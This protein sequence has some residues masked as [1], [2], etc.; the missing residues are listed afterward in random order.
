MITSLLQSALII[1]IVLVF[2]RVFLEKET[3]YQINRWILLGCMVL[4]FLLPHIPLKITIPIPIVPVQTKLEASKAE[5]ASPLSEEAIADTPALSEFPLEESAPAI[6]ARKAS[7]I[8]IFISKLSPTD[9]I[10]YLYLAGVFCMFTHF[11]VQII[12]LVQQIHLH[13]KSKE[14]KYILVE[15]HE[16]KA[17]YSFFNFIFINPKPLD[18]ATYQQVLSHERIHVDQNHSL[19]ILLSQV[20]LIIQWFNPFAW[21]Y[22][23]KVKQNLEY[24]TDDL[25]VKQGTDITDYQ[26]SLL[27]VSAPDTSGHLVLNYSQSLLKKRI[28][29]M[30][31]QKSSLLSTWKYVFLLPLLALSSFVLIAE[32]VPKASP[33]LLEPLPQQ[34]L[35]EEP[36]PEAPSLDPESLLT[37][38]FATE[39]EEISLFSSLQM[40]QTEE[41]SGTW[42][43]KIKEDELCLRV[44][45]SI[46]EED[47]NWMNYDCYAFSDFSPKV[48]D[49][50]SEFS[51]K[52]KAGTITF[53]GSFNKTKGEGKFQ[54]QGSDAYR[55]ELSEKG[56]KN[57][58]EDLLFRL[59]FVRNQAKYVANLVDLQALDLEEET[60]Q[61]LMVDGVKAKLVQGYQEE[62]L[63]VKDH[64]SFVRSRVPANLIKAYT[65]AG[66]DLED[67]KHFIH[68]RVKPDLL[69]SYT[70][71]GL[72]L[73]LHKDFVNSRVKPSLLMA[74]KAAGFDLEAHKT[75]IHSRVK[76]EILSDYKEAGFDLE[77]YKDFI[78]SRVKPELLIA[79]KD[80]GLSLESH[81]P[82]IH[83]RIQPKILT[84][85]RTA[86]FDLEEYQGFIQSRVKPELLTEYK[87]AGLSLETHKSYIHSRVKPDI[88]KEYKAMGY[89]LEEHKSYIHSRVSPKTLKAY[90]EAGLELEEYKSFIQSRV[91]PDMLIAYKEAGLDIEEH[92]KY[93][94]SR[95]SADLL[96]SYKEAGLDLKEYDS[97][98]H[99]RLK[100]DFLTAYKTAGLDL[101][102]YKKFIHSRVSAD[103]LNSYIKQGFDPMEYSAFI[104][105]RI[106]ADLLTEYKDAGLDIE[107][108]KDFILDRVDPEKVKKYRDAQKKN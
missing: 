19:D 48:S 37:A 16:G 83:S 74:Y 28:K 69:K 65:D 35:T 96:N 80:A 31:T 29:M 64:V 45:R 26:F 100:P 25:M 62:G 91:K 81:K 87:Q 2:Y 98:I 63:S 20:L 54:F 15:L 13:P 17:S 11:L 84:A 76:P 9:I 21:L 77:E 107:E 59:F 90:E 102:K 55:K 68:S 30:N 14:G 51:M 97:Y 50:S 104:H 1:S 85:Y 61:T 18:S 89:D 66:L 49:Q 34:V 24:L 3:H 32:Q 70:D 41:I 108:H 73:D 93:I 10:L 71:A 12:S 99:S 39:T 22:K 88:L 36:S 101:Q 27:R 44:I 56:I 23:K 95:V 33:E 82:Y 40:T 58:S 78:N 103:F 60:L 79:Y 6:P 42:E 94:H 46:S 38:P 106:K 75:Y 86:G 4:A 105:R 47:W 72:D 57:A 5:F 7:A 8:S 43:A 67:N 52:R 53:T 92:K